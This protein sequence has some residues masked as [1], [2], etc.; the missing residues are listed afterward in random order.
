IVEII[1]FAGISASVV[2]GM[3]LIILIFIVFAV[4]IFVILSVLIR[5]K[6]RRKGRLYALFIIHRL[7][8]KTCLYLGERAVERRLCSLNT[9]LQWRRLA[10]RRFIHRLHQHGNRFV[11]IERGL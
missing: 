2:L 1:F 10:A 5:Q 8:F 7:A 11:E 3:I 9:L 6:I 4:I